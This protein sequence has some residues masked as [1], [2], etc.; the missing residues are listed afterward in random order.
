MLTL[1]YAFVTGTLMGSRPDAP[2]ADASTPPRD[3]ADVIQ[4]EVRNGAGVADLAAETT[5]YLRRHGFDGLRDALPKLFAG[6][7][8]LSRLPLDFCEEPERRRIAFGP[9]HEMSCVF[10]L[11]PF[12]QFMILRLQEVDDRWYYI[13]IRAMN[14][15]RLR[16]LIAIANTFEP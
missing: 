10:E 14:E 11:G 6:L 13:R 3:P 9:V 16:H 7:Q 12:R 4:V 15:R 2:A 8:D 1:A 5:H